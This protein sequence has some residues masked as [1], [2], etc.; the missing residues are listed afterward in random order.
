METQVLQ[1]P[2]TKNFIAGKFIPHSKRTLEVIT[3]LTGE[4]MS[5]VNLSTAEDLDIAVNAA[6]NAFV[7]WSAMPIK[8]RVQV[9]YRY[10]TLLEKNLK[11]L[12][13]LVHQ[14]NGKTIEEATA[15]VEKS[16][17]LTEFACSLPQL[18]SGELL[19][20][21]KGVECRVEHKPLGVVASIAPFNFPNMVPH[22]TIPNAIALGIA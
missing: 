2:E 6:K 3:P 19:E 1:Y 4:V 18:I 5:K 12:A 10:K 13:E 7:E 15:E 21:S 22:W 14:E 11:A 17:E 20:V 8:E 16:I 9:F